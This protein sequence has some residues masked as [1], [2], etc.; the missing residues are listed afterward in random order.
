MEIKTTK[1]SIFDGLE[2]KEA[3]FKKQC[4]P[5]HFH[6]SYS[7]GIIEKGIERLS[8][9]NK[10]VLAHANAVVIIN[11]YDIHANSYYDNDSWKYRAVYV[12]AAVMIYMQKRLGIH[13]HAAPWFPQE[14]IDDGYLYKLLLNFHET[15]KEKKQQELYNALGY[16]IKKYAVN[17]KISE[18]PLPNT[19]KD[20]GYYIQQN[21]ADKLIID[22]IAARYG[23]DKFKFIR[24]F[25][26]QTGLTPI[27]YLLLERINRAKLLIASNMPIVEIAL[28]T[29]FYDQSHF[30]HYF[31]KYIGVAPLTYKQ[32]I[33]IED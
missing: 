18:A 24:L 19:L 23:M 27:S 26:K 28:E 22:D 16:L 10:E 21:Y 32:G 12:D 33:S 2:L 13:K 7:I 25:K 29:G 14:I 6:D 15:A 5:S 1:L 4:F 30:I 9:D 31:K 17:R 8:F 20:A 3:T 11:P